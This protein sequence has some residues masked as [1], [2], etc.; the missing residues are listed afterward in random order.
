MSKPDRRKTVTLV[1][2][3]LLS[4]FL[5]FAGK[6]AL[7]VIRTKPFDPSLAALLPVTLTESGDPELEAAL[8]RKLSGGEGN[9]V[10]VLLEIDAPALKAPERETLAAEAADF[11]RTALTSS[12]LF[13]A[14]TADR[15]ALSAFAP[16]AGR[17]MSSAGRAFLEGAAAMP[18]EK[19]RA[20]LFQHSLACLTNPASPKL[21]GFQ[22][23]PFCLFDG[24]LAERQ[25]SMR[26]FPVM[27]AAGPVT[28]I[29]D[30]EPHRSTALLLFKAREGAAESAEGLLGR[31]LALAENQTAG[32]FNTESVRIRAVSAGVPLFTDAIAAAARQ[33]LSLIGTV[34]A[35]GVL[36]FA[37][38]LFGRPV[39]VVVMAAT[40]FFG[41][42]AGLGTAF[43]VFGTLSLIT[44][45]FGATLIG[46]TVDYSAH[47]FAGSAG[48]ADEES[49]QHQK[50]LAGSLT[51]AA[52]STAL[53]YGVLAATPLPGLRQMAVLAAAGVIAAWLAVLLILPWFGRTLTPPMTRTMTWLAARLPTLPRLSR[54]SLRRPGILTGLTLF[55]FFIA[56]GLWQLTPGAGIRDLQGAPP[57]LLAAQAEVSSRLALPSPAQI[58]LIEGKTVNEVLA[59]E[60]TLKTALRTLAD[61]DPA[62]RALRPF[63][64]SDW[65]SP[66]EQ[67]NQDAALSAQ[68][69][70]AVA[71]ALKGLLGAEPAMPGA[72]PLTAEALLNTPAADA[73]SSLIL[74]DKLGRHASAVMLAGLTP[75]MLPAL[76]EAAA[77]L[78]GTTFVD[79]TGHMSE[80]LVLYR[81]RVLILLSVGTLLLFGLLSLSFGRGAWRTIL[82]A[83]LGILAALAVLGW[84]GTPF[85][86]FS[87]LAAVLLLGLGADC[88]IFL[89]ASPHNGRAWAAVLFSGVTTMLSFGLLALSSTP[90]LSAFG[91][92]VL[93]GQLVIWAAG[94]L[95][96]PAG[97]AVLRSGFR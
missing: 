70:K 13:T 53:A 1:L 19:Q 38:A 2:L 22:N 94:P 33:E 20:T 49:W 96:R 7:D 35:A 59:R 37:L 73:V 3:A 48:C 5:L 46:V 8:R 95:L 6:N 45:V 16:Y 15:K 80:T 32:R 24:W 56:G 82:P 40:V 69:V 34:S 4:L 23:D 52:L 60:N 9:A 88:G 97:A 31:A 18:P 87:A 61:R 27:T 86:L 29:K 74:L 79:M 92:T 67:E 65:L 30:D 21:L 77:A 28:L 39:T 26:A 89:S 62:L 25:Q 57:A 91:L 90:A 58:F 63:A 71:P 93:T 78:P 75:Q 47:W 51:L 85:T 72:R 84:S 68:A 83:V 64:L 55:V 44:F 17:L 50:N 43:T 54:A 42:A 81:D 11:F 14:E 41:F 66:E 10:T 36:L 12:G 76:S